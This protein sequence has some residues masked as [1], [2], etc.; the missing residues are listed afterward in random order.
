MILVADFGGTNARAALAWREAGAVVLERMRAAPLADGQTP[1]HWLRE[2]YLAQGRPA[3]RNA[4]ACAAGPVETGADGLRRIHFTNRAAELDSRL[5]AQ[6]CG[7]R[8]SELLN[9]FEA[10]AHALP[11]LKPAELHL[12]GGVLGEGTRLAIGAGTGLGVAAWLPGGAVVAG[13]GGHARLAP[14]NAR[15][16]ALL[17]RLADQEG[18]V[19]AEDLLSGPGLLRLHRVLCVEAG[20][21]PACHEAGE[22]WQQWLA[23]NPL[24]RNAVALFTTLLGRYAG[25]LAL[26]FGATGGV[27]LAGGIVPQWGE[28]FDIARFREGF[29]AKGRYRDYAAA[30]GSATVLHPQPALL[31][32]ATRGLA[33]AR[34]K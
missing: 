9:D 4:L 21:A 23:G 17:A 19:A 24:A 29:E 28:H 34:K 12:H 3:L 33:N 1:A 15:E 6:A 5:L 11:A 22:V 30:I 26:A 18:F 16:A 13:E 7:S 2:Y 27:Y 20:I 32:L 8:Q 14:G 10:V 25:D 31:G